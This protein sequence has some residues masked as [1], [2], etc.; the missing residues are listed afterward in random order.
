MA[1]LQVETI[2]LGELDTN[3]Y[4][5]WCE[6]T[7]EAVVIDPADSG[8]SIAD[9]LVS[10]QLQ[11]TAILLT[12]AHFDHVLGTLALQLI[13]DLP[14]YLHTAD[15]E[16]LSG[17]QKSAEHW[18]KH[19]VDPVPPA[20]HPLSENSS[21]SVG[22]CQLEVL[23]TPGHTPGSCSLL[24]RSDKNSNNDTFEFGEVSKVFVGDVIFKD[25][26]GRTDHRYSSKNDLFKSIQKIRDLGPTRVY[27][28][29]GESF[30]SQDNSLLQKHS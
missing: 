1:T 24:W 7:R 27:P 14:V 29:H 6:D 3:C 15:T 5:A 20:T 23:H 21:I 10:L 12:H 9:H 25:G 17:A 22:S 4:I 13:F 30:L 19:P 16:L 28:G 8:E 2:S 18:L 26:I 11:P